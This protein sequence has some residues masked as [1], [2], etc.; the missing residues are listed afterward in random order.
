MKNC[1]LVENVSLQYEGIGPALIYRITIFEN[2]A[3][4]NPIPST[5]TYVPI[6]RVLLDPGH[7]FSKI[8]SV[9]EI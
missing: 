6:I 4:T 5:H 7:G 2:L 1:N 3:Y 9:F 8:Q